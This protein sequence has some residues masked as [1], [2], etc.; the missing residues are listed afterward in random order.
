MSEILSDECSKNDIFHKTETASVGNF[1]V[2][3]PSGRTSE[4][5]VPIAWRDFTRQRPLRAGM[6]DKVSEYL[7]Q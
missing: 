5:R 7:R 4:W 2:A 6:R 3:L 1:K